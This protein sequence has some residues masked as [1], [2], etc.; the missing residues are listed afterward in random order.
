MPR[1]KKG[2]AVKIGDDTNTYGTHISV[3]ICEDCGTQFT[4]CP[5]IPYEKTNDWKG[6]MAIGC[7]SYDPSRDADKLFDGGVHPAVRRARE[8]EK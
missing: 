8:G 4:A 1:R 3:H 5:A 7:T 6:C 2:I